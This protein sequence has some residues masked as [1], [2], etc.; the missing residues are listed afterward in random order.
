MKNK[1]VSKAMREKSEEALTRP[2]NE[3]KTDS[4]EVEGG[5]CMR[6][7]DGKQC[8][9]EKERGKVWKDYMERIMNEDNDWEYNV[10]GDAVESPVVSVSREEMLQALN[11]MKTGKAPGTSEVSLDLLAASGG[12]GIQVMVEICHK[13][14]DGF[15]ML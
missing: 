7:R 4:R 5:M 2:V 15:G 6:G 9:G 11:E 3:Q 12:V 1:A 14:L 8:F 13:V 10:K